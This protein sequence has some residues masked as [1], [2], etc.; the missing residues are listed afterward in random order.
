[1]KTAFTDLSDTR[2]T[3][4]IEIPTDVVDAEIDRVARDYTKRARLPGFRPG[5]VPRSVVRQRFRDDI[6]H[7][8]MHGLIPRAVEQ[9]LQERGIEPV[10]TPNIKDVELTEGH[11]LRF[12][13]AFETVPP[14]DPGDLSSIVLSRPSA[15]VS[16]PAVDQV[17]QR[18]RER[19]ATYETVEGRRVTDDD[20]VAMQLD[21]TGPDGRVDHHDEVSVQLGAPG[22]PPGFDTE[23]V[24]LDV[25]DAKTFRVH[26]P[27]SYPVS[28]LAGT[29]QTYAVVVKHIRR[30][31]LPDP[32]DEFARDVGAFESL[33]ALRDRIRA[34]LEEEARDNAR[35]KVRADLFRHLAAR[36]AFE[37]PGSLVEHEMDRRLEE[38]ARQL[39]AQNV[40]PQQAGI[41]WAQFREAQREPARGAV[42]SALMLDE[43]AR[44]EQIA[45]G[46]EDVDKEIERFAGRA[47]RTPAA[48][49]AQLEKEGG[50]SRLY[51]GLRR[52][53]AVDWALARA[54]TISEAAIDVPDR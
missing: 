30:R 8:V 11:P 14:F 22:N 27:D 17:L 38:F 15:E 26:F 34:D 5:K 29:D 7:D 3:V 28:D 16:E 54:Q 23:L 39:A 45:V 50:I 49:R 47:G 52:E 12:T 41:D 46:R 18:L 6:L 20:T 1:M 25:G 4:A 44:R 37:L 43:I 35:R 32:D 2:K 48:L 31:V 36:V 21:R 9:A 10:D 51:A 42:A 53:K 33:A 13:A 40:D 19:A 24:G